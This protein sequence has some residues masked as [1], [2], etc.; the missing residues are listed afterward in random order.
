[1]TVACSLRQWATNESAS[2][3]AARFE[4]VNSL[5][6]GNVGIDGTLSCP[7]GWWDAGIRVEEPFTS[8]AIAYNVSVIFA[9]VVTG[10]RPRS[11]VIV[12]VAFVVVGCE[13]LN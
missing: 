4:M 10:T 6:N 8:N 7:K 11:S 2:A 5:K 1:M 9:A 3:I 12:I 13:L